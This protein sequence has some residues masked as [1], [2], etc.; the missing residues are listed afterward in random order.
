MVFK[1]LAVK[2]YHLPSR[3]RTTI[4]LWLGAAIVGLVAFL[5]ASAAD[6][7]FAGFSAMQQKWWWWPLLSLPLG[8]MAIRW[9]MEHIGSGA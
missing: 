8:G 5:L 2:L 6:W 7:A 1:R 3:S 9:I 4:A